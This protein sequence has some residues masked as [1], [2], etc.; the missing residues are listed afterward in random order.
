MRLREAVTQNLAMIVQC[1]LAIF[2]GSV[3]FLAMLPDFPDSSKPPLVGGLIA[4]FAGSWLT[5][6]L[7]AWLRYGWKAARSMKMYGND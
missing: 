1:S 6:F 5:M 7:Y 4:G 2:Y 3:V